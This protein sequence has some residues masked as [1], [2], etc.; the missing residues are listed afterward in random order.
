MRRIFLWACSVVLCALP[1]AATLSESYGRLPLTFEANRGQVDQTVRFLSRGLGYTLFLTPTEAVLSLGS[2]EATVVRMRPIGG[3]PD[4][5]MTGASPQATT[6]NYLL[7][8]DS[9]QWRAGVPHYARV[10]VEGVYPGID[11]IYRGNQRQLEYDFVIAPGADPGRIRLAF[12][13][14]DA[15]ELG[16]K[17][18][19]ILRTPNGDLVQHAPVIY[20]EMDDKRRFVEGSF[21]LGTRHEVGFE[22]GRY[23][24]TRPLIIDPILS[25]STAMASPP[26]TALPPR[27]VE[28]PGVGPSSLQPAKNGDNDA[29]VTKINAA[30]TAILYS[31]YL[32]GS[33][34][35]AA[36][37]IALDGAGNF[38]LAGETSSP[39]FPGVGSGSIQPAFG[40]GPNDAFVTKINSTGTAILYSTYLGGSQYDR[41]RGI[42]VDGAG[43]ACVV[44]ETSSPTFPG[45]GPGSIQ[46]AYGGSLRDAFVTKIDPTG[47]AIVYSTYLGGSSLDTA[48]DVEVDT[49]GNS[50]VTGGTGPPT[51]PGVGPGSIQPVYGGGSGDAYVTKIDPEGTTILYSTFLG[52][53]GFDEGS[54][55]AVDGAGN[56][57]VTGGT[58]SITFP[59][60]G[61]GS[62]Q[63]ANAGGNDAFVTKI[64]PEGTAIVQSTFLGGSQDDFGVD[65]AVDVHGSAYVTGSTSSP[66]F[67]GVNAGSIQPTHGGIEDVFVTKIHATG[68]AIVYSTYLGALP[69]DLGIGIAADLAGSA[70]VTGVTRSAAFPVSGNPVQPVFGGNTDGFVAK[71]SSAELN[72]D[73]VPT[74]SQWGLIAMALL[75]AAMGLFGIW[76]QA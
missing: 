1:A 46:P 43:N 76:R 60:I 44:G 69:Q 59:G 24:R 3:N 12:Q 51:F 61:P 66:S 18:E 16:A 28:I 7:G 10:R 17:G 58:R 65:I 15:I 5:R 62:I 47:T 42:A 34:F 37:G 50:Y 31:T 40:G 30:G 2:R 54:G 13:G 29:F 57:W 72:I 25:S 14:A 32:G 52:G 20:Q 26:S 45:V 41:A 22:V 9:R 55:I 68:T 35:D 56:A 63:P 49:S 64:D 21:V 11:L 23:D 36:Y 74:L 33:E 39:D 19:L 8:N 67:P 27:K 4:P 71:I 48:I 73:E 38:Y 75:L 53:N 70:Y 6:S